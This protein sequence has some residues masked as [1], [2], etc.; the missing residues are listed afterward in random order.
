MCL[1]P[2]LYFALLYFVGR[3]RNSDSNPNPKSQS[4]IQILLESVSW[5]VLSYIPLCR[6]IQQGL[7]QSVLR[8]KDGG[9]TYMTWHTPVNIEESHRI[10]RT[11]RTLDVPEC[12]LMQQWMCHDVMD[13]GRDIVSR[14]AMCAGRFFCTCFWPG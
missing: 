1:V 4:Q 13:R 2:L 6:Y 9:G 14:R 5:H 10:H 7:F 3:G 8:Q 11:H 12:L